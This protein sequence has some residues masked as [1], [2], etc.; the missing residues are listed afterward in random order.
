VSITTE[1]KWWDKWIAF[2]LPLIALL[3]PLEKKV[4]PLTIIVLGI[5][6]I[7]RSINSKDF[8]LSKKDLPIYLLL[9]IFIL[10]LIGISYSENIDYA[11]TEIGIKFSFLGFPLLALLLPRISKEKQF[12][13]EISFILGCLLYLIVSLISGVNASLQFNDFSYLSYE[14]LSEP[15]HPTYAATYQAIAIFLLLY[16]IDWT[17]FSLGKRTIFFSVLSIMVVFVSMLASKAGLLTL[18][19]CL[20]MIGVYYAKQRWH[21]KYILVAPGLLIVLSIGSM[22]LL[23]ETSNRIENAVID[24]QS[25]ST[26]QDSSIDESIKSTTPA[27][28]STSLRMVTWTSSL[29]LLLNNPIGVGTGD[30]TNELEKIYERKGEHTALEKSLNAHNQFLQTGAELGWPGL[31][32]LLGILILLFFQSLRTKDLFLL[33][34]LLVCGMNFLFESFLEVQAGIVFFCFWVMIFLRK[35]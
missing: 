9:G 30:T 18:W 33:T 22:Q 35:N 8:F 15:Y 20:T 13:I 14:L 21:W 23:P 6:L 26:N 25:D 11:W 27:Q 32:L 1:H 4:V 24:V 17:E 12:E 10:H 34:F 7:V 19:I 16:K 5:V 29:E 28:S 3:I 2:L 31:I